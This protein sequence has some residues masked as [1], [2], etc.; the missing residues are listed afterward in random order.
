M[1]DN[2]IKEFRLSARLEAIYNSLL[3]GCNI[4][5]F[6]CDHGLLGLKAY[7]S[8]CYDEIFFVDKAKSAIDKLQL[9][10]Y[11]LAH[12]SENLTQIHF[13]IS[14]GQQIN[15]TVNGN[16]IIAGVGA[17]LI[18]KILEGLSL[19]SVLQA[20]RI[21]LAPQNH[22]NTL[23]ERMHEKFDREYFL[24][25]KIEVEEVGRLRTIL[26][27]DRRKNSCHL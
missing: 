6:C 19:N 4:W 21:I 3:P 11:K 2:L 25:Q 9:Q 15:Q 24:L 13:I 8:R 22:L 23:L 7:Q 27:F 18:L 10:F 16:V 5:D 14:M 26:V 12:K 20:Q 1:T 17:A